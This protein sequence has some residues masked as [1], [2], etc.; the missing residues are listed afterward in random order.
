MCPV[1]LAGGNQQK[2]VRARA[3]LWEPAIVLADEPTQGVDVGARAELYRI[4]R[5][6]SVAGVPVVV[7]CS[8]ARELEG[9]CDRV[10]VMSRGHVV[11]TLSGDEVTEERVIR[12]AAE[13]TTLTKEQQEQQE[14]TARP[15]AFRRRLEGAYAPVTVLAAVVGRARRPHLP[16]QR[17]LPQSVQCHLR[18]AL[19]R[20]LA[21]GVNPSA[22]LSTR[23][24]MWSAPVDDSPRPYLRASA[25]SS[26]D[27]SG[28]RGRG[29]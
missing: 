4:L 29:R 12:A 24:L 14:R 22:P 15:S 13:L 6:V 28:P 1:G 10:I 11:A 16:P 17:S 18:A 19:L 3:L 9:L 26:G 21:S 8:D 5:A 20:S 7:A 25:K 23:Q 2:V 27:W